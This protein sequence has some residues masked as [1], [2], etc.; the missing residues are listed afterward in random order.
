MAVIFFI[1]KGLL[2][3]P[4]AKFLHTSY[5]GDLALVNS[6]IIKDL[7]QDPLYQAINPLQL[8]VDTKAKARWYTK[9]GGGMM[10]AAQGGQVTGFRAGRMEKDEFTGAIIIDDPIKPEDA[11]SRPIR[12]KVN[13]TFN[14]TISNRVAQQDVPIILIMQR[15]HEDDLAGFLL[16]G[17][18]E[19]QW[20]H[21]KI[22]AYIGADP[23]PYPAQWTHGI[24]IPYLLPVGPL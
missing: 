12:E 2:L 1:L 18:S 20:H 17:G 6:G 13:R 22:P 14:T 19:E 10:A 4:R 5:S 11:F 21:L 24:E 7:I 15:T 23:K 8:R 3:N 16:K 9:H